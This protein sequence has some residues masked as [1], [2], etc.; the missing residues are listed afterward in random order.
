MVVPTSRPLVSARATLMKHPVWMPRH[1]LADGVDY[2]K[3]M[4]L[5][6]SFAKPVTETVM[7]PL[8]SDWSMPPS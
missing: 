4:R 8:N 6:K 7:R 1:G 3:L 5:L 2:T